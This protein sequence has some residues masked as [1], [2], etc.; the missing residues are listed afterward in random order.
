MAVLRA[1]FSVTPA[2]HLGTAKKTS[3]LRMK[4]VCLAAVVE[5]DRTDCRSELSDPA[6]RRRQLLPEDLYDRR[7]DLC[8]EK[9]SCVSCDAC[10]ML[11]GLD[12]L[13]VFR[14]ALR[15][16]FRIYLTEDFKTNE[17]ICLFLLHVV[18]SF[19]SRELLVW[20]QRLV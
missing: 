5:I 1:Q 18:R 14:R 4:V 11:D 9:C 20:V 15:S 7:C 8:G 12:W 17:R 10:S 3:Y 19:A 13:V 2:V 6:K 16:L